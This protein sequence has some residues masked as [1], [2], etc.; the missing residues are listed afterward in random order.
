[1]VDVLLG[2]HDPVG[3]SSLLPVDG[4]D[5]TAFSAHADLRLLLHLDLGDQP[6]RRGVHPGEVDA[7]GLADQAASSVAANEVLGTDR[8][9]A[10][11][12]DM[13]AAVVLREAQH[14]GAVQDPDAEFLDPAGQDGF[15]LAATAPA[16]SC[17]DSGSR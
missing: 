12:L 9:V 2:Q 1:M 4:T 11:Q 3:P 6:A 5:A 7:G 15:E 14:L 10:R 16:H 8:R 17:G 13:H